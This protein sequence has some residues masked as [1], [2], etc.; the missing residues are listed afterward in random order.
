MFGN[1]ILYKSIGSEIT[2]TSGP[3][4]W[5]GGF[6]TLLQLATT[7]N[8]SELLKISHSRHIWQSLNKIL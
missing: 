3:Q 1:E 5:F 6:R 7:G 2:E 4:S 8:F